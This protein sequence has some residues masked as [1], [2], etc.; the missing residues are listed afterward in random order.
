MAINETIKILKDNNQDFEFYPTTDEIISEIRNHYN[1]NNY[2]PIDARISILDCGAGNGETLFKLA[3]IEPNEENKKYF[4]KNLQA[5]EKSDALRGLLNNILVVGID[6]HETNFWN[7]VPTEILF[8]NPPYSEYEIWIEKIILQSMSNHFYFVIPSRHQ[9]SEKIK[10]AL[11]RKKLNLEIIGNFNFLNAERKARVNVDLVYIYN[12][13]SKDYFSLEFENKFN[14]S[15]NKNSSEEYVNLNEK[16]ENGIVAGKSY[17]EMILSMYEKEK[18]DLFNLFNSMQ[19]INPELLEAMNVDFQK[20]KS[21][22]L[23]KLKNIDKQ[24]WLEIIRKLNVIS[25]KLIKQEREELAKKINDDCLDFNETNINYVAKTSIDVVSNNIDKQVLSVYNTMI[26]NSPTEKYKSNNI[27]FVENKFNGIVPSKLTRRIILEHCGK[28]EKSWS[29]KQSLNN[30]GIEYLTDLLI[31]ARNL[32]YSFEQ[33]V[34]NMLEP[35][36]TFEAGQKFICKA[37][38]NGKSIELFELRAYLKGTMHLK[39]EQRFVNKL[40]I[41]KGRLE[42]WLN[43]VDEVMNEFDIVENEV[44]DYWKMSEKNFNN[45][46]FLK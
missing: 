16:I 37:L 35:L 30:R 22:V 12:R 11:S 10:T 27:V 14:I 33:D 26:E 15:K 42:G 25:C 18:S 5:I 23:N 1:K 17:I 4:Y 6:F 8:C 28:I 21:F 9:T 2:S 36:K 13:S 19:S 38:Y 7:K 31:I 32:G 44:N 34:L 24:Y 39:L 3:G 40:N 29:G 43:N 41:I 20:I 46:L 45:L